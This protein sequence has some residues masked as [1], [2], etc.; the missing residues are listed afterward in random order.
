MIAQLAVLCYHH[1]MRKKPQVTRGGKLPQKTKSAIRT[2]KRPDMP[3]SAFLE[4]GSRKYPFKKKVKG[5]WVADPNLLL[6]AERRARIN[7]N[8]ALANK[9]AVKRAKLT[10]VPK[11]HIKKPR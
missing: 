3:K 9:A 5:K 2:S 10:G 8:T 11:G 1:L 6:A 7:G 4:P